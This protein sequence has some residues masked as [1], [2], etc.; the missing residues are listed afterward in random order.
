MTDLTALSA[1]C[2]HK[3][4]LERQLKSL[5][6]E[7]KAAQQVLRDSQVR[8]QKENLDIRKFEE[9]DIKQFWFK[10]RGQYEQRVLENNERATEAMRRL[11]EAKINVFDIAQEIIHVK[12]KIE[13]MS[14]VEEAYEEALAARIEHL[15]YSIY[16]DE[17]IRMQE[18]ISYTDY[19]LALLKEGVK[20]CELAVRR[21][22]HLY[23][24]ME[25][26]VAL[27]AGP[28]E[29]DDYMQI[30]FISGLSE[31][32]VMLHHLDNLICDIDALEIETMQLTNKLS[33]NTLDLF[34]NKG[35]EKL[36]LMANEKA[37]RELTMIKN[38]L[39]DGGQNMTRLIADIELT[40]EDYQ[41]QLE[42][43]ITDTMV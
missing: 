14:G 26:M 22:D 6:E 17:I 4:R 39:V 19:Q 11:N 5:Q 3:Q 24:L 1:A 32:K 41:K 9:N 34:F 33:I 16:R 31:L 10:L 29:A 35:S 2:K 42:S 20:V 27:D 28:E 7:E 23:A 43:F 25:D 30:Q 21:V 36:Q 15:D 18:K 13:S 12:E 38:S 37:F 8:C 40:K